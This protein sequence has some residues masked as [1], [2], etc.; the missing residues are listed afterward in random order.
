MDFF[1]SWKKIL[2]EK[3]EK[4]DFTFRGLAPP[5]NLIWKS[6]CHSFRPFYFT[7]VDRK[8]KNTV[9]EP[10][11]IFPQ[12]YLAEYFRKF[13]NFFKNNFEI[14]IYQL[15]AFNSSDATC[16]LWCLNFVQFYKYPLQIRHITVICERKHIYLWRLRFVSK[17][18]PDFSFKNIF[19]EFV[20]QIC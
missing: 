12:P 18:Q 5:R 8:K 14:K 9:L 3:I 20:F 17:F 19:L 4:E 11:D 10:L 7:K 1:I 2:A 13:S 16:F 15:S 6:G